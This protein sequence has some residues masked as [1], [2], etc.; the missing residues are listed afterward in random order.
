MIHR[1]RVGDAVQPRAE[2]RFTAKLRQGTVG[3]QQ[4][5]L[6]DILGRAPIL[7][8]VVDERVE[9]LLVHADDE[10]EGAV[11][12]VLGGVHHIGVDSGTGTVLRA[13]PISRRW[14]DSDGARQ[15]SPQPTATS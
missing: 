10:R 9:T 8:D 13:A 12:A 1:G 2:R 3:A 4:S 5:V 15:A 7:Q 14:L 11:I 6:Y